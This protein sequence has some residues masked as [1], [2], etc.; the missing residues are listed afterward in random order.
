MPV[1]LGSEVL[2]GG[3]SSKWASRSCQRCW[4]A[5]S[6]QIG[7]ANGRPVVAVYFSPRRVYTSESVRQA[8]S[9]A[10][11]LRMSSQ[12]S[13]GGRTSDAYLANPPYCISRAQLGWAKRTATANWR[14]AC[15]VEMAH[16][17][18]SS[19]TRS[20][21]WRLTALA[22][23]TRWVVSWPTRVCDLGMMKLQQ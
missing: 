19:P 2:T 10:H 18:M 3:A 11:R 17:A 21:S 15:G 6:G 8:D 16:S 1:A 13:S 5:L 20:P 7:R 4:K 9:G 22:K 12:H 14:W 23:W